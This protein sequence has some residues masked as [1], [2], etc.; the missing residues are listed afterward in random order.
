MA[1]N[2]SYPPAEWSDANNWLALHSAG[3]FCD[4]C[5]MNRR[6]F[7]HE[8]KTSI[9]N[10]SIDRTRNVDVSILHAKGTNIRVLW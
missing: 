7:N 4:V 10:Y 6:P 1:A 5:R 8:G 3:E 2:L 9:G